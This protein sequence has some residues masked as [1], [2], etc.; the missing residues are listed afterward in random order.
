MTERERER[1]REGEE[2][3]CYALPVELWTMLFVYRE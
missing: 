1:E 2:G 3:N